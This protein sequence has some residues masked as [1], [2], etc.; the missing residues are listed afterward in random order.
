MTKRKNF[1]GYLNKPEYW[2]QPKAVLRRLLGLPRAP[3]GSEIVHLNWGLPMEV[4]T[5]ECIGALISRS[6]IF[7]IA[8]VEAIFRLTDPSDI[9]LDFGANIG[10]MSSAAVASKARTIVSFEPHPEIFDQLQRNISLWAEVQPRIVE[11][12][13]ARR[14]AVSDK[15]GI[16]TLRVPTRLF[17]WNHGVSTL[18][19]CS[20]DE[21]CREVE[22]P[23]ITLTRVLEQY[24]GPIGV[25]KIDIEGHE[26]AVFTASQDLFQ[27]G[28]V[29]DIIFEDHEGMDSKVSQFL[30]RFGYS[31]FNLNKTPLG[32]VLLD[33]EA[34]A[35]WIFAHGDNNYL[36]TLDP[37]RARR[38]MSERG[39]T[40]LRNQRI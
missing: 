37:D 7:E 6:G 11:R 26:L 20:D 34:C 8:A 27:E 36:A 29:R 2:L 13:T 14:E 17:S 16:S 12:I 31:I 15:I 25:L 40:C 10:Y 22:V 3:G 5:S 30:A 4:D 21:S 35:K 32:P 33:R 19:I 38:R 18:E 1:L 9:F 23:T 39:F 24:N 28:R